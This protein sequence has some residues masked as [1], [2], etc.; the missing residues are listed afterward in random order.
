M[1]VFIFEISPAAC[2]LNF[3]I[4]STMIIEHEILKDAHE[5]RGIDL[6]KVA[7]LLFKTYIAFAENE[8]QLSLFMLTG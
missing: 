8:N 6:E 5:N 2:N 1:R 7:N 3:A 4:S